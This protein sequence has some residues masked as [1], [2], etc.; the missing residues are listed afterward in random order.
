MV[1]VGTRCFMQGQDGLCRDSRPRLSSRAKLDGI[2]RRATTGLM[3]SNLLPKRN[4]E[5][6]SR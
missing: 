2:G 3:E 4:D 1:Y 6:N 5:K